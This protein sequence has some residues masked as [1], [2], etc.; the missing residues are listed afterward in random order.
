MQT[1]F[2]MVTIYHNPRCSKS[3]AG[4]NYL[5]ENNIEFTLLDYLKEGIS[6]QNIKELAN[7]MGV[8]AIGLVRKHE[9]YYKKEMKG[10]E[11]SD[12]ELFSIIADNPKLLH[13]PIMVVGK[14]AVF[15]QPPEKV[16]EIL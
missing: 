4:L 10:N 12:E 3:R 5:S 1:N 14:K 13:R 11:Y 9:D 16:Q 2:I 8:P 15:A 7:K 6:A